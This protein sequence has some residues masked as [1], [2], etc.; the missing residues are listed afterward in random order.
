LKRQQLATVS[1]LL[2]NIQKDRN[3]QLKQRKQDSDK[4]IMR[5]KSLINEINHKHTEAIK[6]LYEALHNIYL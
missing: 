1:N 6:K 5:N 2:Q 3:D 4:L